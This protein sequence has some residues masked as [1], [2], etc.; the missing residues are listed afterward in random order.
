MTS[1]AGTKLCCWNWGSRPLLAYAA[2]SPAE[3][4]RALDL[5]PRSS[6]KR[7]TLHAG[8]RLLARFGLDARSN[9]ADLPAGG[10][11]SMAE[12]P[13]LLEELRQAGAAPAEWLVTWP[14]RPER[15]RLYLVF[16]DAATGRIGVVK[17]GAGGFNRAQFGNEA[18]FLRQLA[19]TRHPFAVPALLFMRELDDGRSIL[20]LGGFPSRLR[21]ASPSRAARWSEQ[22]IG[23]LQ[24]MGPPGIAHG[25]L[26][27]GNMLVD[28]DGGLFLFDWENASATAPLRVDEVGFWLALNQRKALRH[29]RHLV[30]EMRRHFPSVPEVELRAA[31]EFL[32]ARDNLASANVLEAW[33]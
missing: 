30:A 31:L 7:R 16:R 33:T 24:S 11:L 13:G 21:P 4:L 3:R 5:F 2:G 12:L 18:A 8:I 32:R 1:P 28:D 9:I 26:G 19:N 10:L 27:P 14:A 23:H 17:I 29:P 20:A 25:D 15:R 22:A 6:L